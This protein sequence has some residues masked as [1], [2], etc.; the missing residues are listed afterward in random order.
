VTSPVRRAFFIDC[1]D[2]GRL[3]HI[4]VRACPH[5]LL[6]AFL[7]HLK[8][9]CRLQKTSVTRIQNGRRAV[10]FER[11]LGGVTLQKQ[12]RKTSLR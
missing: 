2:V 6:D 1:A 3:A 9:L 11:L 7:P 10:L 5:F 4:V 12:S 8:L